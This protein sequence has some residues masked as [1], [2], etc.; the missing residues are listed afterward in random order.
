MYREERNGIFAAVRF[1]QRLLC[2][3]RSY[4]NVCIADIKGK[5]CTF[6]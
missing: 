3:E 2:E 5:V 1:E 4:G 6:P